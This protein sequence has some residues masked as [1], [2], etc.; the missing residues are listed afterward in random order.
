MQASVPTHLSSNHLQELEAAYFLQ[1]SY[2]LRSIEELFMHSGPNKQYAQCTA[3]AAR[4]ALNDRL[5]LNLCQAL[6]ESFRRPSLHTDHQHK[7]LSRGA[8]QCVIEQEL[9]MSLLVCL[10][11]TGLLCQ[12]DIFSQTIQTLHK[13][14]FQP[15]SSAEV[16]SLS[17]E[18]FRPLINILPSCTLA[19][20]ERHHIAHGGDM[21]CCDVL[22]AGFLSGNGCS[23]VRHNT[24]DVAE[25]LDVAGISCCRDIRCK[26]SNRHSV[27]CI[28]QG[29]SELCFAE[30]VSSFYSLL[31]QA[32]GTVTVYV[33]LRHCDNSSTCHDVYRRNFSQCKCCNCRTC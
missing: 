31:D 4:Q 10:Y 16:P 11:S 20:A 18:R 19:Y 6:T 29:V 22:V 15:S 2:L 24:K 21:Q 12:H 26:H 13:H 33:S 3:K 7:R 25:T 28:I 8:E 1:R 23:H 27:A 17:G 32:E 5:K 14:V 30:K 9:L